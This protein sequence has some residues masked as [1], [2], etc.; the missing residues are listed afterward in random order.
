[1]NVIVFFTYDI[2]LRDWKD[3]GLLERE[4]LYYERLSKKGIQF[5]F[6]TFGDETD[7]GLIDNDNIEILPI[8]TLIKKSENKFIRYFKSFLI[9]FHIRKHVRRANI[10]K[11]NQLMGSWVAI[12]TKIFFRKKLIIRTGY[13]LLTFNI[14]EKKSLFIIIFTYLLTNFSIIF[15]NFYFVTSYSDKKFLN[16]ITLNFFKN[17]IFLIRNW[18]EYQT[19]VEFENRKDSVLTVGRIE[20]QKNIKLL[21]DASKKFNFK[22][23]IIGDGSL[24]H[25][26]VE[27]AKKNDNV[28]FLGVF[29]NKELIEKYKHYKIYATTSLFEGNPKSLLEAMSSGCVVVA[30]NNSN[31]SE[32]IEHDWNGVLH[33]YNER[34]IGNAIENI[35]DNYSD[36]SDIIGNSRETIKRDFS[37]SKIVEKEFDIYC[38]LSD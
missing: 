8:Y 32:I 35:L 30:P 13:D 37:I 31:I 15:S 28:N 2:S 1:M 36:F 6:L 18:V 4:F 11:T 17:K 3:S 21:I 12:I 27:Y 24:K 26:L 10:L 29:N 34:E 9:P 5:T 16:K 19:K 14:K 33:N 25:S 38:K 23:D 7:L 20:Q 22:L